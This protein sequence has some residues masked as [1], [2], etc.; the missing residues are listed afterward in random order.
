MNQRLLPYA[1]VMRSNQT[2]AEQRLWY[3]LRAQRFMGLKFKRQKPIGVFIADFACMELR[4]VIE[5]DGSQHSVSKDANRDA[6][7]KENGFTLLHFW[8]HDILTQTEM[9]L[10]S[11]RLCVLALSP[12]PSPACG[13]G[14]L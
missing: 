14:E 7:F 9:V 2:D 13:R 4:L 8:N 3:Y 11:I 5:A 10:E 6:W 1:K 12:N